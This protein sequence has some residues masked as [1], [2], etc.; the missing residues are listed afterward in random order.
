ML[1]Y[2]DDVIQDTSIMNNFLFIA[3]L[4]LIGHRPFAVVLVES[5]STSSGHGSCDA[6]V[7]A[8]LFSCF[9]HS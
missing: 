7:G 1:V 5:W 6:A 8:N 9:Q 2:W 4:A 3:L